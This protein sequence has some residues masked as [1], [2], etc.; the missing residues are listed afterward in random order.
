[1][2]RDIKKIIISF[3]SLMV[4]YD[5]LAEKIIKYSYKFLTFVSLINDCMRR[6]I[7]LRFFSNRLD[8]HMQGDLME[9]AAEIF[10][11]RLK[12]YLTTS[13]LTT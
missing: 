13:D 5:I 7:A 6:L 10:E 4:E 11:R 8:Q 1:M 2:L 9:M 3:I 12:A